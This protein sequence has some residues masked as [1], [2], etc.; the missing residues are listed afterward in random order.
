[1]R[2]AILPKHYLNSDTKLYQALAEELETPALLVP[3]PQPGLTGE[4]ATYFPAIFDM[5]GA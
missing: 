4:A 3:V 5:L 1:V 2:F